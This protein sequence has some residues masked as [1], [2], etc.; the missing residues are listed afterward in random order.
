[1]KTGKPAGSK[2]SPIRLTGTEFLRAVAASPGAK[3]QTTDGV[4]TITPGNHILI[5][6]TAPKS[7]P[8]E[9]MPATR[10]RESRA[11]R[12]QR[13]RSP[14]GDDNPSEPSDIAAA[15]RRSRPRLVIVAE[16]EERPRLYLDACTAEDERRLLLGLSL[17]E[18]HEL[19]KGLAGYIEERT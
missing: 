17:G 14:P 3:V 4:T 5:P 6:V 8:A 19:V 16:H 15:S 10:P 11:R 7:S 1:V 13:D 9:R 12:V 2:E 18:L